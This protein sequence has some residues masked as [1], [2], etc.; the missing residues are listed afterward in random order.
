MR[1]NIKLDLFERS[2]T[3]TLTNANFDNKKNE[4]HI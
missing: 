1:D 3:S 2:S 4:Y